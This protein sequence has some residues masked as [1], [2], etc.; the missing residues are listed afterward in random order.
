MSHKRLV[1]RMA[2]CAMVV[3][4]WEMCG[5]FGNAAVGAPRA[6]YVDTI[7]STAVVGRVMGEEDGSPLSGAAVT[8]LHSKKGTVT[9]SKGEF[10]LELQ[11][12]DS[13]SV[14][15]IGKYTR[16]L[17]YTSQLF[18]HVA[19]A[20]QEGAGNEV[21][22]TG[23][24]KIAK[25]QFTGAAVK[26]QAVD[27]K[28]DGIMD[29]SRMLEGR[30]AGVSVQNVSG[31]FGT[32]PKLRIRG[33]TSISGENK[34][35]WVVDGIPLEDVINISNDQLSS[36]N[37]STLLGSAVAGLNADDIETFDILKDASA[38]ALYGAR[39]MNGVIV[40]T[41]KKGKAGKPTVSYTGNFSTSLKP[42]YSNFDIM[43]AADQ[44]SVY[45][46]LERKGFMNNGALAS[47][48]N[49]GVYNKMYSL[50]NTFD[51]TTGNYGLANNPA[52][53]ATFLTRYANNNTDWFDILF[54]NSL[55]QEHSLSISSGSD[56]SQFF[57]STGYYQDN[58]WSVGNNVKRYTAN[59]RGNYT[60]SPKL[61]VGFITTGTVR[62]QRTPGTNDRVDEVVSGQY[63]RNFDINPYSYALNTSR[64][65]TAFDEKGNLEYFSRNFAPFNILDELDNNRM[66]LNVLD[67]KVQGELNY[68]I[69][70]FLKYTAL[71]NFRYVKSSQEQE[72]TEYSNVSKAYRAMYNTIVRNSNSYLYRDPDEPGALPES[73]L[74]KGGLY[75]RVENSLKNF[76]FRQTLS[77]EKL[78]HN[79]HQLNVLVG[80]EVKYANRQDAFNKGFG[81]MY[82]GGGVTLSDYKAIKSIVEQSG[83]YFGMNRTADRFVAFMG[84]ANYAY[85]SK[86]ILNATLRFDGSNKL[87]DTRQAR[88]LPTWTVGGAWNIDDEPFMQGA[89]HIDYLK[90]RISY[91][92]SASLGDATNATI[93]LENGTTRRPRL[94]ETESLISIVSLENSE[95]TWEK[96]YTSNVGMDISLYNGMLTVSAD[97]YKRRSFDLISAVKTSGIGGQSTKIANY[98]DL[99]SSGAELTL[100]TR[101]VKTRNWQWNTLL[102]F[103]YNHNTITN[104][105]NVPRIYDLVIPEGGALE[106]RPVRGLYSL[107]FKGL[108]HD[109][110]M[111]LFTDE[112]G[113]TSPDVYLQSTSIGSL[114][115]EGPVDPTVF[116]GWNN[117]V[118]YKNL[119]LSILIS[120]QLGNKVRLTPAYK[121]AYTDV[122]AMPQ[123]FVNR[124]ALPGDELRTHV[125][126]VISAYQTTALGAVYPY[127]NYNYSTER[128]ASGAFARLKTVSLFYRMQQQWV[129]AIGGNYLSVGVTANNLWLLLAD[130]KLQGQDPEFFASGGVALPLPRQL[131]ASLKLGF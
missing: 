100:G 110:G 126:A 74:P 33:A 66:N 16:T 47:A 60:L 32:A 67:M 90:A 7:K 11:T 75:N 46:E 116:G 63:V 118:A 45:A 21:V 5:W 29:V 42:S 97:V 101:F 65:L 39:A 121:T 43:N 82:N 128:V 72:A 95:L 35:L 93:V 57:F 92:L 131:T 83:T 1:L 123:E 84:S 91:G 120:Y 78:F 26:L 56:L 49:G 124:W 27:V 77:F 87:G 28:M 119:E 6:L 106:G 4:M 103:G 36:G 80:Q 41:T 108:T 130:K 88:W 2:L 48:P 30:A 117:K 44:M 64:T 79:T 105:K 25:K 18:I 114:K 129:K 96:Q 61:T 112:T 81:Y 24:Q 40:I 22:V 38:T 19:L 58:G 111:P 68:K 54:R 89:R 109:T 8:V 62:E 59:M 73:V 76:N 55:A 99:R 12:G 53:K 51:S 10:T 127:N 125:P 102:T 23:Y 20:S 34:P 85:K 98:A 107:Q 104:L 70:S 3:T 15:F 37:A 69:N 9:N 122:D 113:H 17:V 13:L 50:I 71:G 31:T 14:S 94:S 86:Y 52:A 115:Y